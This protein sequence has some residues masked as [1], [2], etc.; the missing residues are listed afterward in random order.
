MLLKGT[1]GTMA[2]R[3]MHSCYVVQSELEFFFFLDTGAI[4]AC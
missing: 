4:Y 3:K 1:K 2:R